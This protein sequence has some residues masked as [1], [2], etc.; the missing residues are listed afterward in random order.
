MSTTSSNFTFSFSK[1]FIRI[2]E[3]VVRSV[4]I[5]FTFYTVNSLNNVLKFNNNAVTVTLTPGNYNTSSLA[6]ELKSKIDTAFGDTNTTISFSAT[7]YK[8]TIARVAPFIV[9]AAISVPTST[10]A[11]LIGFTVSSANAV[12]NTGDSVINLSG[13]NYIVIESAFLTKAIQHRTNY[14]S[15]LYNNVLAVIPLMVAPG[16]IISLD[17]QLL[18]PTRLNYKF[19]ILTTDVIDIVLKDD[20]GNILN[21][22]GS[23]IAIHLVFISE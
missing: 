17:D 13:P 2:T 18:L 5:P 22:N 10:F 7:T 21:L 11:T 4:Q 20:A 1:K 6:V 15:S 3:V 16:D 9:D 14:T 8:L 23:D 12:S 19:D